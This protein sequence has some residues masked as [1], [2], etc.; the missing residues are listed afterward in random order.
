M[1]QDFISKSEHEVEC[2]IIPKLKAWNEISLTPG[3]TLLIYWEL[4]KYDIDT[5]QEFYK[6]VKKVFP[7]VNI[8]FLPKGTEIGVVKNESMG[9]F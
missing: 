6:L 2:S 3:D 5:A 1:I 9:T 7:G 8:L 4:D